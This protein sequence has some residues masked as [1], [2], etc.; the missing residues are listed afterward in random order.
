MS[1]TSEILARIPSHN[2]R[3]VSVTC[4]TTGPLTVYIGGDTTAVPAKLLAG[5]TFGLGD[6]GYA[7]WQAP[8]PPIC[9][10]TT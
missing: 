6:T 9:F 5:S 1:A 3:I 10:K 2:V 4:A 8:L 7:F